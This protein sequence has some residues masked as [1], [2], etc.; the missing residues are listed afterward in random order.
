M[1][2]KVTYFLM[3]LSSDKRYSPIHLIP[4]QCR[5]NLAGI[6]LVVALYAVPPST[7]ARSQVETYIFFDYLRTFEYRTTACFV[8][9]NNVCMS[10]AA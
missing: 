9:P 6:A 1:T 2:E 3:L 4:V 8:H 10:P 5:C 7:D